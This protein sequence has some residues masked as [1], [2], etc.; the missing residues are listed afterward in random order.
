MRSFWSPIFRCI[1]CALFTGTLSLASTAAA[2]DLSPH[3]AAAAKKTKPKAK[4]KSSSS[5]YVPTSSTPVPESQSSF[6]N[7]PPIAVGA[8][9][10]YQ[11]IG[12]GLG[13]ETWVSWPQDFQLGLSYTQASGELTSKSDSNIGLQEVLDIK[14][15]VITPTV[16]YFTSDSFYLSLGYAIAKAHGQFGYKTVGGGTQNTFVSYKSNMNFLQIGFGNSWRLMSGNVVVLDW[17]GYAHLLGQNAS[18]GEDKPASDGS[19]VEQNV[20]FF[21][22]VTTQEH[23]K[24]QLK[25]QSRFYALMLR[26]GIQF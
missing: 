21:E 4:P 25:E 17:L 23:V 9:L 5:F 20:Q 12:L 7:R 11:Y 8:V 14:M 6:G 24:K 10:G 1:C 3:I 18:I 13:I 19:T 15:S 2:E 26:F 16:R 22:G